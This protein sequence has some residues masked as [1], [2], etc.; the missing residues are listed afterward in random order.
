MEAYR[1]RLGV[2]KLRPWLLGALGELG[3]PLQFHGLDGATGGEEAGQ[4]L[5]P[6][7]REQCEGCRPFQEPPS[8]PG[9]PVSHLCARTGDTQ[10]GL[11]K[12][13]P[14]QGLKSSP[15][16][17]RDRTLSIYT[18][19]NGGKKPPLHWQGLRRWETEFRGKFWLC[20]SILREHMPERT[21]FV[22]HVK[23]LLIGKY[24]LLKDQF[25]RGMTPK[26]D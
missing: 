1:N 23:G 14:Q 25:L 6:R 22:T 19:K 24:I 13:R 21:G 9:D 4:A 16:R 5:L 2:K 3:L 10:G 12:P 20:D 7:R 26:R 15:P 8:A 18:L 17:A 11:G